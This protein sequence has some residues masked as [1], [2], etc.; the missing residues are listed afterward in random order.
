VKRPLNPTPLNEF[1]HETIH[2]RLHKQELTAPH[3]NPNASD[4][5][6]R[7]KYVAYV[8]N[9]QCL[10]ELNRRR[11]LLALK[12]HVRLYFTSLSQAVVEF[13]MTV[14]CRACLR[15]AQ[16]DRNAQKAQQA[17]AN[18][19]VPRLTVE[20]LV[21][22]PPRNF[23]MYKPPQPV[24]STSASAQTASSSSSYRPPPTQYGTYA[25]YYPATGARPASGAAGAGTSYPSSSATYSYNPYVQPTTYYPQASQGHSQTSQQGYSQTQSSAA[26]GSGSGSNTQPSAYPQPQ[27]AHTSYYAPSSSAQ[28]STS[29]SQSHETAAESRAR[30]E[31]KSVAKPSA[32]TSSKS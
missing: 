12:A 21:P 27:P 8:K 22:P 15:Q 19:Y 7:N 25:S 26:S 10:R 4:Q 24:A 16:Q 31:S 14:I 17:Q 13:H 23:S 2:P 9:L 11:S 3:Q 30:R 32:E 20:V 28:R 29:T 6:N 1:A 18:K 5:R